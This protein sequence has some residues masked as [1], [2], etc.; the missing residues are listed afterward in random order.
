MLSS[1]TIECSGSSQRMSLGP[2][3]WYLVLGASEGTVVGR[4]VGARVGLCNHHHDSK[5]A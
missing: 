1:R 5:P 3:A 4:C 2:G